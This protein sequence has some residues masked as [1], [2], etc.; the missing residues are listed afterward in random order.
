MSIT[1]PVLTRVARLEASSGILVDP[2]QAQWLP[3][4]PWEQLGEESAP[5]RDY[6]TSYNADYGFSHGPVLCDE[7]YTSQQDMDVLDSI[8]LDDDFGKEF[9]RWYLAKELSNGLILLMKQRCDGCGDMFS[10]WIGLSRALNL[11]T[12][13]L[14]SSTS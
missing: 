12:E 5:S 14:F 6:L 4:F 8:N 9:S 3:S 1:M 11:M 13:G 2:N 10:M 7:C